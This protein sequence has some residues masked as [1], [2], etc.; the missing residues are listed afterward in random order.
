MSHNFIDRM[1]YT[2]VYKDVH[3]WCI[4]SFI[5]MESIIQWNLYKLIMLGLYPKYNFLLIYRVINLS[6]Y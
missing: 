6:I 3:I 2:L 1:T 4:G 5:L